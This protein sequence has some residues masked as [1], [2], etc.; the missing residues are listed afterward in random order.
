MADKGQGLFDIMDA[1]LKRQREGMDATLKRQDTQASKSRLASSPRAEPAEPGAPSDARAS[2]SA[3]VPSVTSPPPPATPASPPPRAA[4]PPNPLSAATEAGPRPGSG[5]Q[6]A[7]NV[8]SQ[9]SSAVGAEAPGAVARDSRATTERL[10]RVPDSARS[11]PVAGSLSPGEVLRGTVFASHRAQPTA[12][13]RVEAVE[14]APPIEGP[15]Q[16]A[17]VQT[18]ASSI[19]RPSSTG[20]S[21]SISTPLNPIASARSGPVSGAVSGVQSQVGASAR[22]DAPKGKGK[23]N[24]IFVSVEMAVLSAVAVFV[25]LIVVF[26]LGW[27]VGRKDMDLRGGPEGPRNG[28]TEN[29]QGEGAGI[30]S[31][32]PEGVKPVN[33]GNQ[34]KPKKGNETK[35]A[36]PPTGT[37]KWTVEVYRYNNRGVAQAMVRRLNQ[38]GLSGVFIGKRKVRGKQELCVCVG[39][40]PRRDDPRAEL[41]KQK[42]INLDR[43]RFTGLVEI[44]ELD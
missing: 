31:G 30:R 32:D 3:P 10:S 8:G 6:P 4:Q 14:P 17:S 15:P 18:T 20:V 22:G 5:I 9:R 43:R 16:P 44:V 39:R 25:S 19:A 26:F 21:P 23:G 11:A 27:N 41:L 33:V 2:D 35:I 7:Q 29:S 38:K 37:G 40:F 24:G 12:S 28:G 42:V 36:A 1:A 34:P 13:G